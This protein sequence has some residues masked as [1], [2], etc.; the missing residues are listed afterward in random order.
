MRLATLLLFTSSITAEI[1][2]DCAPGGN[3]DLSPW[4]LQLPI[5]SKGDPE[6]IS[7]ASLQGCSGFENSDYF[8]TESGDSAL[9]MKV[10]GSPSSAG[11]VTTTNS[12]HCRTEL[13]EVDPS[14]GDTTSWSPKAATNSLTVKLNVTEADNSEHGTVIGQIHIDDS[15]SSKPVCELYYNSD[16]DISVGVEQ[17]RTGGNEAFTSLG[18]VPVGTVFT[19]E[20]EYAG[21]T[22][23]IAIN[24]E[25]HTLD[26][27]ELDA[28]DSYFKVGNYNQGSSPSDI[29]F[30]SISVEH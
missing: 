19:Y 26:T 1:N 28:P 20:M 24:G 29:Q 11:C 27:F 15:V 6:T 12:L 7:S 14:T 21:G 9:V 25:S 2:P 4:E 22:L 23:K 10:P 17:T 16:G 5:G 3:F 30:L 8:F 18:N 13:R